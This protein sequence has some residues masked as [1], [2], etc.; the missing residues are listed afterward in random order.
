MVCR[1]TTPAASLETPTGCSIAA[2]WQFSKTIFSRSSFATMAK[3]APFDVRFFVQNAFGCVAV[4]LDLQR[5][6]FMRTDEN[7][8]RKRLPLRPELATQ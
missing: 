7:G 1:S 5:L 2:K 4:R 3:T 8:A 6:N